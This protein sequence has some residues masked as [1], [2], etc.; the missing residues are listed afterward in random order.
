MIQRLCL[1]L[2]LLFFM[3]QQAAATFDPQAASFKAT[4][5]DKP[6]PYARFS[7]FTLPGESLSL[8]VDTPLPPE[9]RL[10]LDGKVLPASGPGR[11]DWQAPTRIGLHELTLA[12]ADGSSLQL[13]LFVKRPLSEVREGRLNGYRIGHYPASPLRGKEAYLPPAGLVEVTPELV[14]LPLS[15]HFTL[16][17]FLC[18]QQPDHW[19]KYVLVQPALLHKLELLLETVNARGIRTDS[20]HVMSGFRTPWYNARI[21]NGVYS[22]HVWGAAADIFI[23]TT[24]DGR[25]DDLTGSGR[26]GLEDARMLHEMVEHQFADVPQRRLVG[27]L[28]LYGPR[29]HRG[30]FVHVDVRGFNA[31]WELP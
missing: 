10:E 3:C 16:G 22:R 12:S 13:N 25:M 30:P 23:D 6:L 17:Q 29:P 11:W 1:A 20:F 27:G 4:L 26:S 8:R 28:G 9:L 31:R 14:D 18:K 2:L 24:G 7:H 5:N 21:G 15:P 19:P